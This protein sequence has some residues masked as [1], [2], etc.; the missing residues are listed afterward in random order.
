MTLRYFFYTSMVLLLSACSIEKEIEPNYNL[1]P[2]CGGSYLTNH[3]C[4]EREIKLRPTHT[5]QPYTITYKDLE[6]PLYTFELLLETDTLNLYQLFGEDLYVPQI[7]IE[8]NIEGRTIYET[9]ITPEGKFTPTKILRGV[10][11]S[12]D[13]FQEQFDKRLAEITLPEPPDDTVT[14]IFGH[15]FRLE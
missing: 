14:F 7:I 8:A 3:H 1:E 9:K 4:I 13:S 5:F 11:P 10:A 2:I 12:F 6:I 15:M